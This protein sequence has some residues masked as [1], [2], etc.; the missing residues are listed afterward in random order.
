MLTF[1][2]IT[3]LAL[4]LVPFAAKMV[5]GSDA[6]AVIAAIAAVAIAAVATGVVHI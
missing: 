5:F 4:I 6:A 1:A 3:L 2:I